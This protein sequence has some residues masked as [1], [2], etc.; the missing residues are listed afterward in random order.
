MERK[1][2]GTENGNPEQGQHHHQ[3][4]GQQKSLSRPSYHLRLPSAFYGQF[5]KRLIFYE[6][7]TIYLA[8]YLRPLQQIYSNQILT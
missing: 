6:Y 3:W 2:N 8:Y 4:S 7:I 1:N 5:P